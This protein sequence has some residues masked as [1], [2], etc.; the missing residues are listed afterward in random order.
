MK[1]TKVEILLTGYVVSYKQAEFNNDKN[2]VIQYHKLSLLT[3]D[4]YRPV[5]QISI[6]EDLYNALAKQELKNKVVTFGGSVRNSSKQFKGEYV[7]IHKIY[8]TSIIEVAK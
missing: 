6:T 8:L 4:E 1:Q 5:M 2:E 7:Y 3:D